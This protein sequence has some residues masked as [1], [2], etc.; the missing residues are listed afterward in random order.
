[1]AAFSTACALA[2]AAT[3]KGN[4]WR[5]CRHCLEGETNWRLRCPPQRPQRRRSGSRRAVTNAARRPR[6][7]SATP[8]SRGCLTARTTSRN[9][10]RLESDH[11]QGE[12]EMS[13]D[14]DT[15]SA[16]LRD[17]VEEM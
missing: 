11:Y 7:S 17:V 6:E 14:R 2:S 8:P 3:A 10:A 4:C 15:A 9:T 1:M 13:A 16:A 12:A 5:F